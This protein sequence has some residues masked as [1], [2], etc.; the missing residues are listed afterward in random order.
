MET[1]VNGMVDGPPDSMTVSER[2]DRLLQHGKDMQAMQLSCHTYL[3]DD[4]HSV[5]H[6]SSCLSQ[7]GSLVHFSRNEKGTS[8]VIDALPSTARGLQAHRYV[9]QLPMAAT[10]DVLAVDVSQELAVVIELGNDR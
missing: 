8:V 1:R 9:P 7:D 5:L 3:R 2:L 10:T 6:S 4:S